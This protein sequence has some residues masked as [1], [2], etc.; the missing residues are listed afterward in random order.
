M[1]LA[2]G[3]VDRAFTD[4]GEAVEAMLP[5]DD[6]MTSHLLGLL[7]AGTKPSDYITSMIISARKPG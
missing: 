4:K 1:V 7:P 3:L 5:V 2:A 6:P